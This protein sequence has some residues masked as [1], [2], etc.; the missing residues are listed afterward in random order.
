MLR[1][2]RVHSLFI[3][4]KLRSRKLTLTLAPPAG[5]GAAAALELASL[6]GTC[7]S[8]LRCAASSTA[9]LAT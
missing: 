1:C 6:A 3:S 2:M 9:P 8:P 7:A 5:A 4:A